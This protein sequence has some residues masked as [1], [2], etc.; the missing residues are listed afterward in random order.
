M[1]KKI[2]TFKPGVKSYHYA[3]LD[4]FDQDT[5]PDCLIPLHT[6]FKAACQEHFMYEIDPAYDL[7]AERLL[8]PS[9]KG[10]IALAHASGGCPHSLAAAFAVWFFLCTHGGRAFIFS[11]HMA[12]LSV[13]RDIIETMILNNPSLL[14]GLEFDGLSVWLRAA[15]ERRIEWVHP[16]TLT[17][18][19]I[20]QMQG[21]YSFVFVDEAHQCANELLEALRDTL[22]VKQSAL[23]AG[24]PMSSQGAFK[25]LYDDPDFYPMQLAAENMSSYHS[26]EAEKLR[27]QIGEDSDLYRSTV[28]AEFPQA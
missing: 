8:H 18:K 10:R 14:Y 19:K 11:P 6:T 22:F 26:A 12:T 4:N 25:K 15:P 21:C 13:A 3:A 28:L 9:G 17:D 23:I 16:D 1:P 20:E 7:I 27:A 5:H 24:V 2:T